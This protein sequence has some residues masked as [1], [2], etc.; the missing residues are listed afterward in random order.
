VDLTE[1]WSRFGDF[2]DA[3]IRTVELRPETKS[4]SVDLDA[5]DV[6]NGG[7]WQ[8]VRFEFEG[9]R[10]WRFEQIRSDM[11]VIYE[12]RA[13]HA[14]GLTFIGFD[15]ATMPEHPTPADF[16]ASCAFIAAER[17]GVT[18]APL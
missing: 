10:E 4:A 3:V 17:V 7:Q 2:H 11:I 16:R 14:D 15:A 9:M 6:S 13:A 12:A 8:R 18:T 5:E 1:I